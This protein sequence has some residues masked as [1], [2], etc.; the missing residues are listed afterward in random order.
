MLLQP[1]SATI[2]HKQRFK[3]GDVMRDCSCKTILA[4]HTVTLLVC[5]G[6]WCSSLRFSY[7]QYVVVCFL[8]NP[9]RWTDCVLLTTASRTAILYCLLYVRSWPRGFFFIAEPV[10]S[11]WHILVLIASADGTRSWRPEI[12][13][14]RN[15]L[16]ADSTLNG[17]A[18]HVA[19]HS[20]YPW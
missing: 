12:K 14:R 3:Y 10:S 17:S 5:N 19:H 11:K 1:G 4:H 7:A 9:R 18:M 8:I 6:G 20:N 16:R 2:L 13:W 15:S